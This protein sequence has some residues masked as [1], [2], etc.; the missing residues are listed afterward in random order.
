[1]YVCVCVLCSMCVSVCVPSEKL[2]VARACDVKPP[3]GFPTIITLWGA[4]VRK[5]SIRLATSW[6]MTHQR[7]CS[8][9]SSASPGRHPQA[10]PLPKAP[11]RSLSPVPPR[12]RYRRLGE[13]ARP[14]QCRL[15]HFRAR[16]SLFPLPGQRFLPRTAVCSAARRGQETVVRAARRQN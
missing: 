2:R 3:D 13:I 4:F 11:L 15:M 8:P 7:T 5:C 10:G 12:Q 1:M 14:L 6:G 9:A 16:A